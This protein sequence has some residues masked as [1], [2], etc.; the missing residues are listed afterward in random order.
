[1]KSG[2]YWVITIKLILSSIQSMVLNPRADICILWVLWQA[3]VVDS[4]SFMIIIASPSYSSI[5][6]F[7]SR[8]VRAGG[9]SPAGVD[10]SSTLRAVRSGWALDARGSCDT[11]GAS[12]SIFAIP[13]CGARGAGK[14]IST[15]STLQYLDVTLSVIAVSSS[16]GYFSVPLSSWDSSSWECKL[17]MPKNL[18]CTYECP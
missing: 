7:C 1:M 6:Q 13:A 4:S 14:P 5:D 17:Y 3:E 9:A 16:D 11:R 10:H 15:V 12:F 8:S 18:K 2:T